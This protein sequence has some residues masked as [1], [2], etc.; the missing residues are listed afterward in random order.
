MRY[1]SSYVKKYSQWL[2][3]FTVAIAFF[4]SGHAVTRVLAI[5]RSDYES[6]EAFTRILAI[7]HKNYVEE[8]DTKDLI[9]GAIGGMLNSLDPHS[10]YLNPELYRDLQMDT[11]G[12]FA[13]LGIEIT[14]RNGVLTVVSPIEDTR[15]T[16]RASKREIRSLRSRTSLP[17]I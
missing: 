7:V 3:L 10:A 16:G 17:R 14:I 8:V 13:G 5:A 2:T 15:P 12:R 11:Q 1:L 9:M 4:L 6:L